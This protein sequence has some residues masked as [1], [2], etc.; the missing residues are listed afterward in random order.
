MLLY[1]DIAYHEWQKEGRLKSLSDL[2]VLEPFFLACHEESRRLARFLPRE[3][4]ITTLVYSAACGRNQEDLNTE[5]TETSRRERR[6][7]PRSALFLVFSVASVSP[8]LTLCWSFF[9]REL[10][11]VSRLVLQRFAG[12][13]VSARSSVMARNDRQSEPAHSA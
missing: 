3:Q 10:R 1:L 9:R 13:E 2:S 7:K 12:Y 11:R 4:E 8:L 6:K 5:V